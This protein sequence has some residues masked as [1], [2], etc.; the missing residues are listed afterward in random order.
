MYVNQVAGLVQFVIP[1]PEVTVLHDSVSVS[2]EEGSGRRAQYST[3]IY[4]DG[5]GDDDVSYY[6]RVS[7]F[8]LRWRSRSA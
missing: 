2:A 1:E 8:H 7:D 4:G 6:P 3:S 5:R